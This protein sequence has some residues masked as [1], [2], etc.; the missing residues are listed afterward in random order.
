MGNRA[1]DLPACNIVHLR[2]RV[3]PHGMIYQLNKHSVLYIHI[4]TYVDR[5]CGLV[6]SAWLQI[7]RPGFDSRHYQKKK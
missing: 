3:P 6:V 7:R 1:R 2:Y 5:L 4:H